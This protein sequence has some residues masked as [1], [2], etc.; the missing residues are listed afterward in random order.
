MLS[1]SP[2]SDPNKNKKTKEIQIQIGRRLLDGQD[3][4]ML[5]RMYECEPRNDK[6]MYFLAKASKQRRKIKS[7]SG[8]SKLITFIFSNK[9]RLIN[10][11]QTRYIGRVGKP[12]N[13]VSH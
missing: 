3:V 6:Y 8:V 7:R 5:V 4:R 2:V 1:I 9:L 12:S 13:Q 10:L 11:A